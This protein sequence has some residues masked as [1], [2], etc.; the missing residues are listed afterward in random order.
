MLAKLVAERIKIALPYL[1]DHAHFPRGSETM[2]SHFIIS[3]PH[4]PHTHTQLHD[5]GSFNPSSGETKT[6]LFYIVNSH[7][8][9]LSHQH[10]GKI[11]SGA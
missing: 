9:T 1:L 10:E 11:H 5:T 8:H 6:Y 2:Y 7:S 3:C 4:P